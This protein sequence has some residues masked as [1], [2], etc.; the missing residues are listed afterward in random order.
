MNTAAYPDEANRKDSGLPWIGHFPSHWD[1]K[2]LRHLTKKIGSGITP[3]GGALTYV[4]DG[5]PL[6]RSQNVLFGKIE[7]EGDSSGLDS[8]FGTL[9][10]VQR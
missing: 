6:L 4:D 7:L 9:D 8:T 1:V 3:T 10:F 5:I 2:R